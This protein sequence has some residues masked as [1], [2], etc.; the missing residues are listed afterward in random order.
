VRRDDGSKVI[1][2]RDDGTLTVEL[3]WTAETTGERALACR[4]EGTRGAVEAALRTWLHER[5]I[6][7]RAYRWITEDIAEEYARRPPKETDT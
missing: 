6:H 4:F 1:E 7:P 2:I 3:Y 5:G